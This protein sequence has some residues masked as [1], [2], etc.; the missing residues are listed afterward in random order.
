MNTKYKV[1]ELVNFLEK[2]GR[3][4]RKDKRKMA[5]DFGIGIQAA[6][7][8]AG[9]FGVSTSCRR[10]DKDA[11]AKALADGLPV[12]KVA[13]T[14]GVSKSSVYRQI[15]NREHGRATGPIRWKF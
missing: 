15:N 6:S 4:N 9:Y 8:L 13:E 12:A 1:S 2:Y 7:R 14:C 11:V 5:D 3:A 10:I